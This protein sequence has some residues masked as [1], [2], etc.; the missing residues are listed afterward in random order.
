MAT[1]RPFA[2]NTG[3]TIN[4]TEQI[5]NLAVGVDLMDYSADPGGV[6]WWM[7]PDEEFGYVIAYTVPIMNHPSQFGDVSGVGFKRSSE[8]TKESLLVL[9][10][11]MRRNDGLSEFDT[12]GDG[13]VWL[14]NNSMWSGLNT[15]P[16]T[17]DS[18]L[19]KS[20]ST[21]ITSDSTIIG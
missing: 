17:V 8:K 20:D 18:S 15:L 6:K 16:L 9:I 14:E 1:T 11:Y 2:Y 5:G 21:L 19:Y 12:I 4:G 7:G 3:S 13:L 10:N